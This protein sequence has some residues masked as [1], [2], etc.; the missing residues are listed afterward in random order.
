MKNQ[1]FY[2]IFIS[3]IIFIYSLKNE[4]VKNKARSISFDTS[5]GKIDA[6]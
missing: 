6:S 1:L 4:L 2:I 3:N 5:E